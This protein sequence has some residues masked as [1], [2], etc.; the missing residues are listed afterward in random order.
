MKWIVIYGKGETY[1]GLLLGTRHCSRV[2]D[3]IEEAQRYA[4]VISADRCP[5]VCVLPSDAVLHPAFTS[6]VVK[7]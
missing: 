3:T 5:V 7:S 4:A 6:D 1:A 2:M